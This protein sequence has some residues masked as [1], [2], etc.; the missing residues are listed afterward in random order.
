MRLASFSS[1]SAPAPAK[2]KTARRSSEEISSRKSSHRVKTARSSRDHAHA[3]VHA[4]AHS[5]AHAKTLAKTLAKTHA[6]TKTAKPIVSRSP[7][8]PPPHVPLPSPAPPKPPSVTTGVAAAVANPSGTD[9]ADAAADTVVTRPEARPVEQ[10]VAAATAAADR[11]MAAAARSKA[12]DKA[13]GNDP[14]DDAKTVGVRPHDTD[15]LVAVLM[16]HPDIG[17]VSDLSRKTIAI[18]E[19]Y[20]ATSSS[21][22]TAIV[23]AGAPEVQVSEEQTAA[24]KRLTNG[25]VPAAVVA[26]VSPDAAEVFPEIAGFRIFRVPLSPNSVKTRP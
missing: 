4:E 14:P 25:E 26:L 12:M 19:R 13:A 24:I 18:D 3:G 10:L 15:L 22:R 21:I 6:A 11:M 1:H 7:I 2:A 9:V 17:S 20:S 8:P 16:A 5:K 23:A